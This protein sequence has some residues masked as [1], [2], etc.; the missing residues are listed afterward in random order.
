MLGFT[1]CDGGGETTGPGGGGSGGGAGGTTS[2]A[3]GGLSLDVTY[4]EEGIVRALRDQSTDSIYAAAWTAD[5]GV[6]LGGTNG[7]LGFGADGLVMRFLPD[8]S[9]DQ[10]YGTGGHVLFAFG[11]GTDVT[12]IEPLPDGGALISAVTFKTVR[13]EVILQKLDAK[14]A[15]DATFGQGG[16]VRVEADIFDR[17]AALARTSAGQIYLLTKPES[18]ASVVLWRF[19]DSGQPDAGFGDRGKMVLSGE[20]ARDLAVQPDDAVLVLTTD[21]GSNGY[22][23]RVD[24][25]GDVDT[26]FGAAGTVE[27]DFEPFDVALGATGDLL[28][29]GNGSAGAG[30]V[31]KLDASGVPDP[32]FGVN[33]VA[34]VPSEEEL[35]AAHWLPGGDVLVIESLITSFPQ[36]A[37]YGVHR[38]GPDGASL[39]FDDSALYSQLWLKGNIARV[40]ERDGD[41]Y[42]PGARRPEGMFEAY[43]AMVLAL[44]ADGSPVTTFADNGLAQHGSHAAPEVSWDLAADAQGRL[45]SMGTL[46]YDAALARFAGGTHDLSFGEDGFQRSNWPGNGVVVDGSGRILTT[47]LGFRV[48]R[49]TE[50]GAPDE[51]FG[52]SGVAM[53]KDGNG[54]A[55]DVALDGE[56]RI[57]VT[58]EAVNEGALVARL[59]DDG[60]LDPSFGEGGI[61]VGAAGAPGYAGAVLVEPDG[62]LAI[63]GQSSFSTSFFARLLEDGSPDTSFGDGGRTDLAQAIR[64]FRL[65][66]RAGGGYLAAGSDAGCLTETECPLLVVA[67]TS[68][69]TLDPGFGDNGVAKIDAASYFQAWTGLLELPS[70]KILVGGATGGPSPERFAVW[71]LRPNGAPESGFGDNGLFQLAQ[72]GRATS[73]VLD[74]D[75]VVVGGWATHPE[76]G[77]DMITVRFAF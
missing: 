13:A 24:A 34:S 72:K 73:A 45:I 52:M 32:L 26:G 48:A 30:Q 23:A 33:G 49:Y 37:Y 47:T 59:L 22:L 16:I 21:T 53:F 77:S 31:L 76:S 27:L 29:T 11:D 25:S 28:V 57:V 62:K 64:L 8:G 3:G 39:A 58:G 54:L 41:L 44:H 51:S 70:G 55:V 68:T 67:V 38:L 20:A 5:G 17:F 71:L 19:D 43:E 74:G 14:G 61:V 9:L 63:A 12:G 42:L 75:G 35:N 2:G 10:S 46:G 56:K 60:S 50:E 18:N 66:P 1:G 6:L 15:V 69:G 40:L 4:G 36:A 7:A 65:A